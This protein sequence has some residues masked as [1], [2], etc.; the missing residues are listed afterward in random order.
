MP[1]ITRLCRKNIAISFSDILGELYSNWIGWKIELIE[2]SYVYDFILSCH[3]IVLFMQ[4][5]NIRYTYT[6]WSDNN[7]D[8][9]YYGNVQKKLWK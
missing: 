7:D 3:I 9:I 5:S 2:I 4:N 8:F 6:L 1:T